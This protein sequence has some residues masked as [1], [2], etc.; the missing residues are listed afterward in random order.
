[1][2]GSWPPAQPGGPRRPTA[3]ARTPAP[4]PA[5]GRGWRSRCSCVLLV[6][7]PR[8]K[9]DFGDLVVADVAGPDTGLG[10]V[11][12]HLDG[13]A[14][15]STAGGLGLFGQLHDG[16][17]VG[18][19]ALLEDE[20]ERRPAAEHVVHCG[21]IPGVLDVVAVVGHGAA[22]R[23]QARAVARLVVGDDR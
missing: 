7:D 3:L 2:P 23:R 16:H 15:R 19:G 11:A 5:A 1:W 18:R 4:R 13:A 10:A 22:D 21:P 17:Q 12:V 6:F 20:A 8:W 9:V 14:H